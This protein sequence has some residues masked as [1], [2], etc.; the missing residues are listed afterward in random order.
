MD[1]Y[2]DSAESTTITKARAIRELAKHGIE[3]LDLFFQD[4]GKH[5]TYSAQA[6]LAWLGY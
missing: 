4:L 6:V 5:D 1:T 3:N 2:Y